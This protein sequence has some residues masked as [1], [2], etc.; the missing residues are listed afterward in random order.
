MARI[1]AWQALLTNR[2]RITLRCDQGSVPVELYVD[3]SDGSDVGLK[4]AGGGGET[5]N[6]AGYIKGDEGYR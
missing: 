1:A 2:D 3:A 5:R 4:V 6:E